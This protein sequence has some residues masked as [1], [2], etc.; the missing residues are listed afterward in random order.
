MSTNATT[1]P[2]AML[3]GLAMA[4]PRFLSKKQSAYE[5]EPY[6]L[7]G[8]F[9]RICMISRRLVRVE[10]SPVTSPHSVRPMKARR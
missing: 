6:A 5:A 4:T 2:I 1:I 3:E 9:R 10:M 7:L 8:N